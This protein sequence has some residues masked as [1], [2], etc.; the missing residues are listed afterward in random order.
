MKLETRTHKRLA[1]GETVFGGWFVLNSPFAVEIMANKSNLD[2]LCVDAQHAAVDLGDSV[3]LIRAMQAAAPDITPF[4]RLPTQ[5]KHWIEQSLD[6]GYVGFVVPLVESAKE[7]EALVRAA[8]YPPVGARSEA[9]TIRAWMYDDYFT[10][11]N[12]RL[13]LLPQIESK[14]GLEHCEEIVNVPGVSGVLLGPGDLSLSCGWR[15]KD[16]WSHQPFLDAVERVLEACRSANKI[17]ATLTA[18]VDGAKRVE[19]A[20]FNHIG[21]AH[22]G[23]TLRIEVAPNIQGALNE[24]RGNS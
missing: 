10:S 17:A 13:I 22:D 7:A 23:L 6:A 2:Y 20:G 1:A 15:G 4:I 3:H 19:K 24:L 8:Y 21:F 5:H 16:L 14:T 9:G 12:D 18:G 11:I